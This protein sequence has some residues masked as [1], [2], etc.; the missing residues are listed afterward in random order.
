MHNVRVAWSSDIHLDFKA[1]NADFF[2]EV[3]YAA[4]DAV[5]LTGDI[6]T[7]KDVAKYLMD[8]EAKWS[9][10]IY[11]VLGNHD[12]YHGSMFQVRAEMEALTMGNDNLNWMP[13]AGV[14]EITEQ[15]GL[16]GVDGWY[17][18]R[19]GFTDPPKIIMNDWRIIEE[20]KPFFRNMP[21]LL[22]KM[23]EIAD[24][25]ADL[26][27]ILLCEAA[28]KYQTV[29]FL[30]HVPPWIE[31]AWHEHHCSEEAYQPWFTS[32][33]V[34]DA[35]EDIAAEY[36]LVNFEVLCGHTHSA[37]ELLVAPNLRCKTAGAEYGKPAID[38]MLCFKK[39]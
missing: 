20:L 31:A 26:A 17:D 27:R 11:F 18:G 1:G 14:V 5:F 38:T 30:T 36:P 22:N 21:L 7:A 23:Q 34:G 32:K 15:V 39:S 24:A 12:Y 3:D 19:Y 25:E 2:D 28:K 16:C 9:I 29:Y 13:A 35:L 6:A 4:P 37:G 33:A 8:M 10:P